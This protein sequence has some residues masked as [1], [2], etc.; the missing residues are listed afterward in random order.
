MKKLV[1]LFGVLSLVFVS[2]N[3]DNNDGDGT[4]KEQELTYSGTYA[5]HYKLADT[6]Y[7]KEVFFIDGVIVKN[8]LK[9][10]GVV[11]FDQ[12][13]TA[14]FYRA[15]VSDLQLEAIKLLLGFVGVNVPANADKFI[16]GL[17]ATAQFDGA[18]KVDMDLNFDFDVQIV[19]TMKLNWQLIHY[20]G[21]RK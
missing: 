20:E 4:P 8:R 3:K 14:G 16:K 17:N 12:T 10:Y 15:N 21:L 6:T 5:G 11:D 2:C 19:D 18:G 7:E 9:L 1:F 13:D